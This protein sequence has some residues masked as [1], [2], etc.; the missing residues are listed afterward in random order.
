VMDP[1]SAELTKYAANAMLAARIS[2]MNE[3]ANYCDRVGADVRHVRMGM[4][5]DS[6]I[7]SS[8]LFPGVGYGG[9]CFP[10]DVKALIRMGEEAG[11]PLHVVEAT[12]RTNE[13]QKRVLVPRVEAHLG[14]LAGKR[15]AV[16]GLAFKPKTDDM[17]EA[18]AIAVI[19]GLLAGGAEV[20]AYDPKAEAQ[21]RHYFGGRVR[22][23]SRAYEAVTGA[24]ALVVVTEWNEFREP[25]FGKIRSLMRH[26][27][28]FDGRN[29]YDPKLLRELGF[30][31]EGIGRR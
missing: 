6:R 23:C 21:A 28:V 29:I 18:P 20:A 8:F 27:A 4:G 12:E 22:L 15:I 5:T 24:D 11:L 31:Y 16:W 2:F 14:G 17:R 3:I 30:H 26:A 1:A 19:E 7:G 13:E 9:S 10:K 25:D